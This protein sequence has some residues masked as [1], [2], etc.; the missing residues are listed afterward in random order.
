MTADML[1]GQSEALAQWYEGKLDTRSGD[2]ARKSGN[3]RDWRDLIAQADAP[4]V[5]R[6]A[7]RRPSSRALPASQV[8]P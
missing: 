7:D 6:E 1:N 3:L 8:P 2:L 4:D 5:A